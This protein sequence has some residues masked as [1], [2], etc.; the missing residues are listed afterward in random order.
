MNVVPITSESTS[1][2]SEN[3]G[4]LSIEEPKTRD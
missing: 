4:S 2:N 3:M 1:K